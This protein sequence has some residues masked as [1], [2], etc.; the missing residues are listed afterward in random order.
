MRIR[1]LKR[2]G[3]LLLVC[4]MVISTSVTAFAS[5]YSDDIEIAPGK[6]VTF[7]LGNSS[8][9]HS[10]TIKIETKGFYL[11]SRPTIHWSI[12][13]SGE[14]AFMSGNTYVGDTFSSGGHSVKSG[15]Y[16]ITVTNNSSWSV[17]VNAS[18]T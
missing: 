7:V 4:A 17:T 6:T 8:S 10:S 13:H 12:N 9:T 18:M 5:T 1:L 3:T 16:Y 15:T 11:G 2:I 14:P